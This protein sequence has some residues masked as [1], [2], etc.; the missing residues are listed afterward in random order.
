MLTINK[1]HLDQRYKQEIVPVLKVPKELEDIVADVKVLGKR[2]M[3]IL[4]R[5]RYKYQMIIQKTRKEELQASKKR[6]QPEKTEQELEA[7][8][9]KDL[10][11]T[12]VRV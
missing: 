2:E 11:D 1:F 6:D 3:E 5:Y 10:Q 8:E 4:L 12:I 7:E 9:E